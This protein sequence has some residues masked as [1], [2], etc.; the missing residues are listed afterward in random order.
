MN[1]KNYQVFTK[2]ISYKK[3][4]NNKTLSSDFIIK[5]LDKTVV[6]RVI[7][8]MLEPGKNSIKLYNEAFRK[9]TIQEVINLVF[10][11]NLKLS[12]SYNYKNL[13]FISVLRSGHF[14][15][16]LLKYLIYKLYKIKIEII[17]VSPNH[18]NNLS[19][20]FKNYI[21]LSEKE[22][23]FIDGWTSRGVTYNILKK[24]WE[25]QKNF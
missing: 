13:V 23:I 20:A 19:P 11:L 3:S 12:S 15:T 14:L 4:R 10:D 25:V 8:S 2:L 5:K 1:L 16:E 7:S 17:C 6:N 21:N 9:S 22:F 18:I 24:F